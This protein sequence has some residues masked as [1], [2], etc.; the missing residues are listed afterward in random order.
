M[1]RGGGVLL[2]GDLGAPHALGFECKLG[3]VRRGD[4]TV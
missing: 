4:V 2:D 1:S 3:M